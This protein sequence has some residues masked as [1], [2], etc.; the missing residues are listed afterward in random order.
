M[1]HPSSSAPTRTVGPPP[2]GRPIRGRPQPPQRPGH[3]STTAALRLGW[4]AVGT[5]MFM[6]TGLLGTIADTFSVPVGMAGLAVTAFS[7][8]YALGGPPLQAM[9]A[10]GS[11]DRVLLG[12]LAIFGLA[13]VAAATAPTMGVLL[14][15]QVVGG[16]AASVWGPVSAASAVAAAGADRVGRTLGGFHATSSLAMIAGA[17]AG[18]LLAQALSWRAGFGLVA[19]TAAVA[20]AVLTIRPP[21]PITP[22]R[23]P[24]V[25]RL[26]PL[27]AAGVPGTLVGTLLV[28]AASNSVFSYLGVLLAGT[29]GRVGVGLC[30]VL[31]GV[32]GIAGTWS[33]GRAA[34]RWGG[35][36]VALASAVALVV[37]TALVP[38]AVAVTPVLVA[39]ILVWGF[40]GWT[41]VPAQQHRLIS[42]DPASASILLALLSSA[43]QLGFAAG[44]LAGGLVVDAGGP[45][46]LWVVPLACGIP[47]VVG[48]AAA[49]RRAR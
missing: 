34:D 24:I 48:F 27:R 33:G 42:S 16:L 29:D 30:L 46:W 14:A 10:S 25:E 19:V 11:S 39:L 40:T 1:Q 36:P 32:A 38:L 47:A 12:S 31:F 26:R 22:T 18:L 41:F 9:L 28:M 20:L 5:A 44:A 3:W 7:I 35:L 23:S 15:A 6:I 21:A 49:L 37:A 45:S 17:P 13:A 43:V 8:A 2:G 4:F